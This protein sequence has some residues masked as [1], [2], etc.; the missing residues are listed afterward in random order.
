MAN[1]ARD[2]RGLK[3]TPAQLPEPELQQK[4]WL[5]VFYLLMFL[6]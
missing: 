1:Y 3:L 2:S 4:Q 6:L 5:A